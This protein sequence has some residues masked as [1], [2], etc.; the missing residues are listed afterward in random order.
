MTRR[1]LRYEETPRW[2]PGNAPKD[3]ISPSHPTS[4]SKRRKQMDGEGKG[5]GEA[6]I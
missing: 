4:K 2:R 6:G 1:K 3:S 5:K